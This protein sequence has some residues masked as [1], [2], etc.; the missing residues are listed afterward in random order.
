MKKKFLQ[1]FVGAL[2]I[3]S[4]AFAAVP[5]SQS[6]IIITPTTAG[7]DIENTINGDVNTD[8]SRINPNRI[9]QLQNGAVYMQ[10]AHIDFEGAGGT[11]T[12]IGGDG[13]GQKPVWR[14]GQQNN[15][16]VFGNKING[17]LSLINLEYESLEDVGTK[18]GVQ[19]PEDA[20]DGPIGCF[21]FVGNNDRLIIKDCLIEESAQ[22]EWCDMNSVAQGGKVYLINSYW[23]DAFNFDQWWAARAL[24]YKVPLDTLVVENCTFTSGGLTLLGQGS[25]IDF[26]LINHNSFIL[27]H[28]YAILNQFWNE[29]YFTNNIFDNENIAGEDRENVMTGGQDPDKTMPMGIFGFDSIVKQVYTKGRNK[30]NTLDSLITITG[31]NAAHFPKVPNKYYANYGLTGAGTSIGDTTLSDYIVNYANRKIFAAG[32]MVVY[33]KLFLPYVSGVTDGYSFPAGTPW[34][35]NNKFVAGGYLG[36]KSTD[37]FDCAESNLNLVWGGNTANVITKVLNAPAC[38]INQRGFNF[39]ALQSGM[40]N[41][42]MGTKLNSIYAMDESALGFSSPVTTQARVDLFVAFNRSSGVYG[43]PGSAACPAMS[44]A[45]TD[46]Y[47]FGDN[48]ATTWAGPNGETSLVS[49]GGINNWSDLTENLG[50]TAKLYSAIDGLK[51]GALTWYGNDTLAMYDRK[52]Q[53][54]TIQAAYAGVMAGNKLGVTNTNVV[55]NSVS[56]FPNPTSDVIKLSTTGDVKVYNLNGQ[57]VAGEN[58]VN[59]IKVANLEAGIYSVSVTVNGNTTYTKVS[60]VR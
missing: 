27:N 7:G 13:T 54:A 3:G 17:N 31:A 19:E 18:V 36:P 37:T 15:L 12:I 39:D 57:L 47:F 20:P 45:T 1:V 56:V 41:F 40:K 49:D 24:Q 32:N 58:N 52:A 55:N 60:V 26:A 35:G 53:I 4:S 11:L 33:S 10:Y 48:D 21:S 30:L 46:P 9:Y 28:R 23:R 34:F 16:K 25:V 42:Q 2:V 22:D 59:Q 43:V 29:C 44:D 14:K 6:V 51:Y 5:A 38:W 50:Y 8:G